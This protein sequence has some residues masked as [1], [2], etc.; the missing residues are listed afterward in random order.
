MQDPRPAKTGPDD[1]QVFGNGLPI[2]RILKRPGIPTGRPNWYWGV[3]F[4]GRP[5]RFKAVWAGIRTGVADVD[6]REA[7][8]RPLIFRLSAPGQHRYTVRDA[9]SD[10]V[11]WQQRGACFRMAMHHS[12]SVI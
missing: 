12:I 2:G 8:H 4:P 5:Q 3:A 7:G 11:R 1:H 9:I 6:D 10:G